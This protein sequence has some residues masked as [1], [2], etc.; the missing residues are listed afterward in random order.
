[1]CKAQVAALVALACLCAVPVLA[2]QDGGPPDDV[3]VRMGPLSM[4]PYFSLTNM[5]LDHNVFNDPATNAPKQDFT[6]TMTPAT[7]FWLRLGPTWLT[8]S[9]IERIAWY[10]KYASERSASTEYR[11]GW[12]VPASRMSFKVNGDWRSVKERPGYEIDGRVN[13]NEFAYT[14]STEIKMF[15]QT[16]LGVGA[17]RVKV[18]FASDA[19]FDGVQLDTSLN[20]HTTSGNVDVRQQITTL[21]SFTVNATRSVDQ[22]DVSTDRDSTTTSASAAL[23]FQ[24]AALLRGGVS[25][26][27]SQFRPH[28]PA[29]P[30]YEGL[31]Y[32]LDLTYVLLGSTRFAA[33]G[34]R[35]VQYSY[36]STQPYYVQTG[37]TGSV[38]Q[39]LFG[40]LD[41]AVR[42]GTQVLAYRDLAGAVVAVANRN[43]H[44]NNYGIGAGYHMGKDLRLSFNVDKVFRDSQVADWT[45]NNY[46][47]T[48][49]LTYGF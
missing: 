47:F 28:S 1:M 13:R 8:S 10:Q 32:T 41:V 19:V 31:T 39:E 5:G 36:D 48:S 30:A 35:G 12:V 21:T 7:D 49:S 14:G 17:G 26:G 22:F 18:D 16:F 9:L 2:Q 24:P 44:V 45:Y 6:A 37:I 43:D 29:L 27:Y 25:V 33:A 46:T 23:S 20:R 4:N 15:S 3:K 42:A 11:L 34:S 38:A 40:P